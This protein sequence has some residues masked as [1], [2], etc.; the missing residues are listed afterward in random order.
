MTRIMETV[1]TNEVPT[2]GERQEAG[3]IL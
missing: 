1:T 3:I 2:T